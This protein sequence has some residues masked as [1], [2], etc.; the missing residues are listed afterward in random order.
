VPDEQTSARVSYDEVAI[1]LKLVGATSGAMFG[2]PTL[3]NRR[4]GVAGYVSFHCKTR[5]A[6][7]IGTT[8]RR[9]P[10]GRSV[11]GLAGL[12]GASGGD[13]AADLAEV[14]GQDAPADPP[15]HARQVMVAAAP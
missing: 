14:V 6:A 2:M 4:Q 7:R 10:V 12:G 5:P 8:V 1:E 13:R 15:L 11:D 3:K 9:K